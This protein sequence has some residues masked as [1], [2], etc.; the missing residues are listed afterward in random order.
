M[1]A[2]GN[3]VRRWSA[4]LKGSGARVPESPLY[5]IP[6]V[7]DSIIHIGNGANSY[8]L[9]L[10]GNTTADFVLWDA[11]A[12]THTY[13]GAAVLNVPAGQLQIAGTAITATAAEINRVA[14]SSSRVVTSAATTIAITAVAHGEKILVLS[15]THTQTATLPQATGSGDVYTILVSVLGTDGSKIIKVANATDVIN[16]NSMI[17]QSTVTLVDGFAATATDDTIT[18]NNTTTG[19]YVGDRI[20][21]V[22]IATGVFLVTVWGKATGTVATPFS[23]GV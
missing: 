22:D 4:G 19:G 8:D 17:I 13:T 2:V 7:D 23:S 14:I 16:G 21:I 1:S 15:S 6:E 5:W 10:W 11:S 12:N 18:L 9:K 20:E 3:I